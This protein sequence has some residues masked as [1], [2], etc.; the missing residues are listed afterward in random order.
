MKLPDYRKDYSEYTAKASDLCRQLAFAGIAIVWIFAIGKDADKKLAADL[1]W[2]CV[3]LVSTLAAD[4]LQ[5]IS[6]S[7]VWDWYYR[8]LEKMGHTD[9]DELPWHS[10]KLTWPQ[11]IFFYLK[12]F[13]VVGAYGLLLS[14]LFRR[15]I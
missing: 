3:F 5:Y 11:L 13:L 4:F 2:P 12:I 10:E 14:A 15:L 7:V 1:I 8:H 6:A 9:A